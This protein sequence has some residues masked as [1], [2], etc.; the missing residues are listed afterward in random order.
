MQLGKA[1]RLS[2]GVTA[3]RNEVQALSF[4]TS[5]DNNESV[6]NAFVQDEVS[7]GPHHALLAGSFSHYGS[8]GDHG[9]W[10]AEY[11]Y[12]LFPSTRL[13]ASAGTGFRPPQTS[14]RYGYGGNPDL[15]PEESRNYELGLKQGIGQYQTLDLRLFR[16]DITNLIQ[17]LPPTYDV[18]NVGRVRNQ[19][20]ELSYRLEVAEWSATVT[21]ILQNPINRDTNSLLL[22]RAKR[23]AT[24]QL[25]RHFGQSYLGVEAIASGP[26]D[27]AGGNDGGYTLLALSGG[28]QLDDHFSLQG[29]IDNLLDKPYETAFGYRQPGANGSVALRYAF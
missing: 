20:A 23:S 26:R 14:E 15:K 17:G 7:A 28:L 24:A 6:L 25:T 8:F 16:N 21:G 27:D 5:I 9:S 13:I 1:N 29:R 11:G 12:D 10:N 19:G 2:F 3:A 22:R 18:V 4:G